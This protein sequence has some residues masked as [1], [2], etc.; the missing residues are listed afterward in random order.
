MR[1]ATRKRTMLAL[2]VSFAA[3]L[4]AAAVWIGSRPD[5]STPQ[6]VLRTAQQTGDE[7]S[8]SSATVV[9]AR[10]GTRGWSV[11][12]S[13]DFACRG[14]STG[15]RY[16]VVRLLRPD[17]KPSATGVCETLDPCRERALSPTGN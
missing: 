4:V 15:G 13:G 9:F 7:F 6:W 12:L 2:V 11:V 1:N 17:A 16:L 10:E 14:C 8:A 3:A 5:D